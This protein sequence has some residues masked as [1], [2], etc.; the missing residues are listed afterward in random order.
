[1]K[2]RNLY[3]GCLLIAVSGAIQAQSS[4]TLEQC[5]ELTLKNNYEIR[6]SELQL[7]GAEQS[8]KEAFT[9]YF[10]VVSATGTAMNA[11]AGTM[12]MEM[13]GTTL[14]LMK[15]GVLGGVTATQPVFAGGNIVNGNKLAKVGVEAQRYQLDLSE[16]E[17]LLQTE[18]YYYQIVSLQEKLR[19]LD[20]LDA[21]L[22]HLRRDVENSFKAGL[23]TQNDVLKVKLKQNEL[24]SN[25]LSVENG[26]DITKKLLCQHMGTDPAGFSIT[27]DSLWMESPANLLVNH[28]EVLSARN[29]YKLLD[30]NVEANNL[31]LKIKQGE[32]LPKVA[33][34]AGYMYHNLTDVNTD[35]GVVFATVSIPISAWWGG[36][37]A[38]KKQKINQQV[39]MN[40]RQN[41]SEQLLLQMQQALNDM[42]ESYKQ[43]K[44]AEEAVAEATENLR[45]SEDYYKAGTVTLTDLLDAQSFL[46]QTRD[47]YTESIT[48]Y[49]FKRS[50]YL[51]VTGRY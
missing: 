24:A 10:P 9:N 3:L 23:I 41:K 7:K 25:R 38:I 12:N 20:Q 14:S 8:R 11:S 16:D 4:F 42:A 2:K 34:G 43:V 39:A 26:L 30:K 28:T 17:I 19:T 32:F 21:M 5:K 45:L 1:M 44:L 50:N 51:Q 22:Q 31:Q 40:D 29:E 18:H 27:Y 37:H 33:V 49:R 35:F 6:K 13:M 36:S 47:R 48:V 46:Q 15:N